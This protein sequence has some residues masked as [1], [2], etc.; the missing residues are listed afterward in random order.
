MFSWVIMPSIQIF[1]G[2]LPNF[3]W[4]EGSHFFLWQRQIT[5]IVNSPSGKAHNIRKFISAS[6]N[7]FLKTIF[8][9]IQ[10]LFSTFMKPNQLR[11]FLQI[12]SQVFILLISLSLP[13]SLS[14][15]HT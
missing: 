12:Q 7:F 8:Q 2:F 15:T 3:V 4:T 5:N 13:V 10:H 6:L 14:P 1:L 9:S 11:T